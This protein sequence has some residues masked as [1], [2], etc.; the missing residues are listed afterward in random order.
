MIKNFSDTIDTVTSY[1][2]DKAQELEVS[3]EC[4]EHIAVINSEYQYNGPTPAILLFLDPIKS[5]VHQSFTMM[6]DATFYVLAE[7]QNSGSKAMKDAFDKA[8][9]LMQQLSQHTQSE[10]VYYPNDDKPLEI[11]ASNSDRCVVAV[12]GFIP[13][14]AYGVS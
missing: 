9:K 3:K 11:V 10:F 7:A 4:I 13:F 6:F 2:Q 8:G 12:Y 5:E 14:I 1:L